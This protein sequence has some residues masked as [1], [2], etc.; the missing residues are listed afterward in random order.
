MIASSSYEPKPVNHIV[1]HQKEFFPFISKTPDMQTNI[2]FFALAPLR[3]KPKAPEGSR[4]KNAAG[5][6]TGWQPKLLFVLTKRRH[7]KLNTVKSIARIMLNSFRAT[8][9]YTHQQLTAWLARKIT[10]AKTS[11]PK[12]IGLFPLHTQPLSCN[13]CQIQ[14]TCSSVVAVLCEVGG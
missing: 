9:T 5:F 4:A 7:I 12:T 3:P 8:A 11:H 1:L 2:A 13:Q 10:L 14:Y 6:V